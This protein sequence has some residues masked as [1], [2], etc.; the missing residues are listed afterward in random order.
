MIMKKLIFFIPL[1]IYSQITPPKPIVTVGHS[2]TITASSTI[3]CGNSV[4]SFTGC[5]TNSVTY[6]APSSLVPDFTIQGCQAIPNDSIWTVTSNT[7]PVKTNSTTMI[8]A[9]NAFGVVN[10]GFEF[11]WGLGLFQSSNY[12]FIPI[13]YTG[14][15]T[16]PNIFPDQQYSAWYSKTESSPYDGVSGYYSTGTNADHHTVMTDPSTCHHFEEYNRFLNGT[17]RTCNGCTAGTYTATID[18]VQDYLNTDYQITNGN[19]DAAGALI[20]PLTLTDRDI[21]DGLN[22]QLRVTMC[23]GC[24]NQGTSI[25]PASATAGGSA[26]CTPTTCLQLGD[27]I[28]I[29]NSVLAGLISTYCTGAIASR[30]SNILTGIN[31]KGLK[32]VDTG[33]TMHIQVDPNA[34]LDPLNVQ[35]LNIISGIPANATNMEVMDTSSLEVSSASYNVCPNSQSCLSGLPQTYVNP[36]QAWVKVGGII[37]PISIQGVGLGLANNWPSWVPMVTGNYSVTIPTVV[38]GTS[39]LGVTWTLVSGVGS[40][41]TGGIYTPPSSI[42]SPTLVTLLCT[43]QADTNIKFHAFIYVFPST[44]PNIIQDDTLSSSNT[45]DGL[46]NT[47]LADLNGIENNYFAEIASPG[48]SS[49]NNSTYSNQLNTGMAYIGGFLRKYY[50]L[51]NG[52]YNIT[53]LFGEGSCSPSFICG[54]W[55]SGRSINQLTPINIEVNGYVQRHFFDWAKTDDYLYAKGSAV[56][57]PATVSNNLLEIGLYGVAPDISI[58]SGV[59]QFQCVGCFQTNYAPTN[60]Q[61][62]YIFFYGMSVGVDATSPYLGIDTADTP[63]ITSGGMAKVYP[64]DGHINISSQVGAITWSLVSAPIG[65]TIIPISTDNGAV[66]KL[67]TGSYNN[68]QYIQV[69]AVYGIYSNVVNIPI[70]GGTKALVRYH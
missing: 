66:I 14:N 65:T 35:A 23:T 54:S 12:T 5:G 47:W 18:G 45:I 38:T 4:G 8:N 62:K 39:N 21:E 55:L 2:V 61:P 1:I 43:S 15:L 41:T 29:K 37:Y 6:T 10:F 31:L 27:T 69:K 57:F 30:C 19:V 34:T 33:I 49:I 9:F 48:F 46:G 44:T 56:T 13:T 36:N 7:L 24:F 70:Q 20:A 16:Y 22:H 63:T 64:I 26:S 3:T 67:P 58:N 50:I 52:N 17:L 53:V 40:I 25:W 51:P 60:S 59:Y 42:G 32:V 28:H 11:A 68:S